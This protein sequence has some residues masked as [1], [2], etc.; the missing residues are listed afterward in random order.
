MVA[1]GQHTFLLV[2]FLLG[3][4]LVGSILSE[5]LAGP[6]GSSPGLPKRGFVL[7]P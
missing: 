1:R 6:Y 7:R 2:F 3:G 4:A 5:A